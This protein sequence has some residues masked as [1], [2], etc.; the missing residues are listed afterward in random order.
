[1]IR[2]LAAFALA[3]ALASPAAAQAP[4][5]TASIAEAAWLTGRWQGQGLGGE[6]EE[7]FSAPLAGQMVGHFRLAQ[8]G[9][10]S[11]YQLFLIEEHEGGLVFRYRHFNSDFTGWEEKDK[12]NAFA[13]VSAKP[14][15]LAFNGLT[16]RAV[17]TDG[18]VITI[19]MRQGETVSDQTLRLTRVGR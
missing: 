16:L 3:L 8:G 10:T 12:S 2:A 6:L 14:G 18:L 13:F 19:R 17:G 5:Q 7:A 15:E 11:F 1:M 4:A 9:K